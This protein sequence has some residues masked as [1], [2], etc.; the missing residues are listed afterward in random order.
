MINDH[1]SSTAAIGERPWIGVDMDATLARYVGWSRQG[2]DLGRPVP[3]TLSRVRRILREGHFDVRIMT[4][5]AASTSPDREQ[6]IRYIKEWCS[7]HLG[8]ELP[9]TAEKDF[10]M[11]ALI[12]D[13]V[14][15]VVPN[16][17]IIG[18]DD[19]LVRRCG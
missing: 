15:P 17:G 12:D 16:K 2:K 14:I 9:V 4:A 19:S 18:V 10:N 8:R 7:D 11:Y 6:D 13:R 5:R 1:D 3:L